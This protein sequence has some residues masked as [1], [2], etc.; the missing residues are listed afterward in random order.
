[1]VLMPFAAK[2]RDVDTGLDREAAL[3]VPV[4]KQYR[5]A[6]RCGVAGA[7]VPLYPPLARAAH[8]QGV[9]HV[10]ITTDGTKA[11]AAHAE[12]GHRLLA[13]AA[14][15]N[16]RTWLFTKHEPTVF[17]VTYRY[18]ISSDGDPDNPT[19]KL[20]FPADVEVSAAPF[21]AQRSSSRNKKVI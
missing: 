8:V 16:A 3:E 10:K 19:V 21:C 12:D 1:M 7:A 5:Y 18:R 4:E 20:R 11:S 14:E 13:G 2:E 17:A 6:H 9:V 15:E